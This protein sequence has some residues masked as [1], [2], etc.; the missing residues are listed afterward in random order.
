VNFILIFH[1]LALFLGKIRIR[2]FG[3]FWGFRAEVKMCP[4]G[5]LGQKLKELKAP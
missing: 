4:F 5:A 3:A 2:P 1:F